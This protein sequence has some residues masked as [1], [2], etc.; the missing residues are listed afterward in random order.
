MPLQIELGCAGAAAAAAPSFESAACTVACITV[1]LTSGSPTFPAKLHLG[2]NRIMEVPDLASDVWRL[3]CTATRSSAVQ[4]G[5]NTPTTPGEL[6]RANTGPATETRA[7]VA[8]AM[9]RAAA[10]GQQTQAAPPPATRPRARAHS[11]CPTQHVATSCLDGFVRA[12]SS[13]ASA[14]ATVSGAKAGQPPGG[15]ISPAALEDLT[16]ASAEAKQTPPQLRHEQPAADVVAATHENAAADSQ[17]ARSAGAAHQRL[18]AAVPADALWQQSAQAEPMVLWRPGAW[19]ECAAVSRS[20]TVA[21]AQQ[22]P[23]TLHLFENC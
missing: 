17:H 3:P 7:A 6:G 15:R 8:G 19:L 5:G 12:G 16:Y 4:G 21:P 23:N 1:D 2:N 14:V 22:E 10:N 9:P 13:A 20:Y 11:L 18:L